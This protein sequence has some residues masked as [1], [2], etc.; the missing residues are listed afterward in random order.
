MEEIGPILLSALLLGFVGSGHC[1]GMCG[2]IAGA[3]GQ[4]SEP[5]ARLSHLF[6]SG[7]YSIG[8]IGSYSLL[9]AAVGGLGESLASLADFAQ[10]GRVLAGILIV[11][12]GIHV[13]G[14][15]V[16]VP[17]LEQV[18]L[19]VWRRLSP[20]VG[21]IG[22]PD[23]IWKQLALGALWGWLPCGLVYSALA[24]ASVTGGATHGA[25]FMFCF[26]IGTM[27]ALVLATGTF[28]KVGSILRRRTARR[29]VG[30]LLI[31]FGGWTIH[32]AI[33]GPSE[34]GSSHEMHRTHDKP[35]LGLHESGTR[36]MELQALQ[37]LIPR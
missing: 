5:S 3:L 18:G 30:A 29:S 25:A 16:R 13:A 11:A 4:V 9:G 36:M 26:G 12:F 23:R 8:R 21:R 2:G 1:L 7:L 10:T 33:Q 32:A 37:D 28:G 27:P 24:A 34:H 35:D 6:S 31:L 19:R 17:R 20:F 14:W 15:R 22:P